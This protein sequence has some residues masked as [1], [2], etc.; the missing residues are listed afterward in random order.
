MNPRF[1]P[2]D[3]VI[4]WRQ[5]P[6]ANRSY[7]IQARVLKLTPRRIQI[8]GEDDGKRV[9]RYVKSEYLKKQLAS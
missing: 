2:G 9:I 1:K 7:P 6:G 4:W 3:R 5:L 8:E